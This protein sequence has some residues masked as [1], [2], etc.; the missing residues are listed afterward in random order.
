MLD[1]VRA[2][3]ELDVM[4]LEP[5]TVILG[6]SA[7]PIL[8]GCSFRAT[9][10]VDF[11]VYPGKEVAAAV[12]RWPELRSIFDLNASGVM[13]LLE[14]YEDRLVTVDLP[15]VNL[16]VKRLSLMDWVVSKLTSPKLDDVL[17]V[18]EVTL[19]MLQ[20]IR[21]QMHKY[22]GVGEYRASQDLEYLISEK[23]STIK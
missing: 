17:N 1:V 22:C 11:A 18:S 9:Q 13:G 6:G 2:L 5:A 23:E 20:G 16:T 10:D 7:V 15:Y 14:D 19:E 3:G 21:K 12:Q 4:L 8:A